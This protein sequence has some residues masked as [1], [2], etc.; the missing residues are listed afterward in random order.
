MKKNNYSINLI[1]C[2]LCFFLL[3]L[4][5]FYSNAY[6]VSSTYFDTVQKIYIGYY[7][8]PA[9]PAG[10]IYWAGRLDSSGGNL[11]EII[12]AF[13]NSAESQELY[14]S[15]NSGNI[16][17]VVNDIYN[18]LCARD[19]EAGG[20]DYYVN[21]F[22]SGQF[23]AATIMLNVLNGAQNE[24]LQS[25][26]NKVAAADL[27][28]ETIDP[29]LDGSDFR[30]T[31][32][33][34][35]DV[36]AARNFLAFVTWDSVTVPTQSQSTAYIQA[37]ISD[38]GDTLAPTY[39]I[40]GVV[41]GDL[42]SGVTITLSGA[43]SAMTTTDASGNY[44]FSGLV[45]GSYT[46]TPSLAGFTFSPISSIVVVSGA[47]VIATNFVATV[48]STTLLYDDFN[49]SIV[50]AG[51]WRIPTWE[52][53]TDGTYVGRTQFRC[54]QNSPLP[55]ARNSNAIIALDTYNPTGLSFYGTDL[56][57]NQSFALGQGFTITVRAKMDAPFPAGIVGGIFLY[58]PP[59]SIGNTFHDEIDFELLGNE[60]NHVWTN[61]YG[62]EPLGTGHPEAFAY[63]SGSATDYHT[64]Q[65]QWL[66]DRVSWYVDGTLFRTVT[67]Q[68]PV[69]A[70]PMYVHLNVW[71]PYSDFAAA[72]DP[73]LHWESSPSA[74]QTFSMSVDWV[75]VQRY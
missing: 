50:S 65:I 61:I 46:V 4:F 28:T 53:P 42:L 52:S 34:D 2:F 39:S 25:V 3:S 57:S 64:Y 43:G 37:N 51:N 58:A 30:I 62:N 29:E 15:I 14:G 1:W 26:N 41:A 12:E 54:S 11:T 56:I 55:A 49:G 35:S 59:A 13:A 69:P 44:G 31:Y 7:Q 8:R 19:A 33:G 18:A 16:S 71:V 5:S 72:Y 73:N 47:S 24:D 40:S 9:D 20:R 22:N 27:F 10:L 70:G 75:I 60:P 67:T 68:S 17:T 21:R 63:A 6:P 32:S 74:N 45:N 48:N 36:T 38:P 23:T 66:P